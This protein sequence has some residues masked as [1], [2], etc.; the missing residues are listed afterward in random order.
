MLGVQP[1][2]KTF[3]IK[4]VLAKKAKQN[5]PIPQWIR[6]RTNNKIRSGFLLSGTS[7]AEPLPPPSLSE[8]LNM[9][10]NFALPGKGGC[11]AC[12]APVLKTGLCPVVLALCQQPDFAHLVRLRCPFTVC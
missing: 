1:S 8:Q 7:Y 10:A 2:Q 3:K 4:R 11:V 12:H 9:Q 6:F 5:R